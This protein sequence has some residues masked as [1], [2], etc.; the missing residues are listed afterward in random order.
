MHLVVGKLLGKII[1]REILLIKMQHEIV[2]LFG[3][4]LKFYKP[5][6]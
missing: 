5:A 3:N 1:E 2:A 6:F 4:I